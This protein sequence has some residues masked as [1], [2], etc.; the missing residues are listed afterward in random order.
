MGKATFGV[1]VIDDEL[2][3]TRCVEARAP[4]LIDIATE[5]SLLRQQGIKNLLLLGHLGLDT[6][7]CGVSRVGQMCMHAHMCVHTAPERAD[8]ARGPQRHLPIA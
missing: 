5:Y 8:P 3:S 4:F 1:Q 2:D 6:G 7:G